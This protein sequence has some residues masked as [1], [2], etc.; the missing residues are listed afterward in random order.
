MPHH[1]PLF[2]F[3]HHFPCAFNA[4]VGIWKVY[5]I[6]VYDV[7]AQTFQAVVTLFFDGFRR[8]TW[9]SVVF[10]VP[11][12]AAFGGDERFVL[13]LPYRFC[14]KLFRT[15]LTVNG[16]GIYPVDALVKSLKYGPY[17]VGFILRPPAET[18]RTADSPRPKAN[19]GKFHIRIA[20]LSFLH[21]M[22]P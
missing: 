8:H 22:P 18:P 19:G 9:D 17:R 13:R 21:F 15:P 14:D 2:K 6:K 10:F 5:L 4:V 1:L 3:D 11:D 12:K 16:S 7:N 20:K